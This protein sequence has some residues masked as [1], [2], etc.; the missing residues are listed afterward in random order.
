MVCLDM[1]GCFLM[2]RRPPRSTR[3]NTLFPYTTLVRSPARNGGARLFERYLRLT[4]ARTGHRDPSQQ[5]HR[6]I[7]ARS[8]EHTSELQSLMRTSYPVFCLQNKTQATYTFCATLVST[9]QHIPRPHHDHS[10]FTHTP[11][12][13]T[14]PS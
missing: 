6:A 8:E 1:G 9:P 2:I 13:S 5:V 3:T 10:P 4:W 12:H 11:H 7:L 14:P